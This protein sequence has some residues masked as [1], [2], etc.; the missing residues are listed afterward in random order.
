[1]GR[2]LKRYP[3]RKEQETYDGR[4]DNLYGSYYGSVF[5]KYEQLTD[6][7]SSKPVSWEP[8]SKYQIKVHLDNGR[9]QIYNGMRNSIRTVFENDHSDEC[10]SRDFSL[11]LSERM[12]EKQL[13][14]RELSAATGISQA[15]LSNYLLRKSIPSLS[16]AIRIADA[17]DC[18]VYDLIEC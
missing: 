11:N 13:T 6:F 3:S 4:Y 8:F 1:M 5:Y 10:I 2:K 18:N 9:A 15:T 16:A 14:Q 7:E 12:Y 17:L